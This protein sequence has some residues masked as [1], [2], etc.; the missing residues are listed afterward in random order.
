VMDPSLNLTDV[1]AVL[2]RRL[3]VLRRLAGSLSAQAGG[4]AAMVSFLE[5]RRRQ[6]LELSRVLRVAGLQSAL[7]QQRRE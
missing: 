3:Q 2:D 7:G 4:P 6:N 1:F 5:L